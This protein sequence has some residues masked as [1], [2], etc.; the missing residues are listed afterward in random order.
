MGVSS[1]GLCLKMIVLL[2]DIAFKVQAFHL[3][4]CLLSVFIT[5]YSRC[6]AGVVEGFLEKHRH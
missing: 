3:L 1:V 6:L 4:V 5:R 2:F